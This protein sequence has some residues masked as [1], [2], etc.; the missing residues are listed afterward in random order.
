[1]ERLEARLAEV[2]NGES[3]GGGGGAGAPG[4][5]GGANLGEL[6]VN[7]GEVRSEDEATQVADMERLEARLAG[8]S[9]GGSNVGGGGAGACGMLAVCMHRDR[10]GGCVERWR[11]EHG[12][13]RVCG[14]W[15]A[16]PTEGLASTGWR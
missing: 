9:N 14:G 12:G 15:A 1:M 11:L 16:R 6:E 2:R 10:W 3:N 5:A 7:K 8:I 4:R 13:R